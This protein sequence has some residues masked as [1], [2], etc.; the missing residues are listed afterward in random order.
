MSKSEK[1]NLSALVDGEI[2]AGAA[3][4]LARLGRDHSLRASWAR[5]HLISACLQRQLPR[6]LDTRLPLR[7]ARA[8]EAATPLQTGR[9][10]NWLNHLNL[11]LARRFNPFLLAVFKPAA[12]AAATAAVTM[13]AIIFV[14][15]QPAPGQADLDR[16][17]AAYT[18]AVEPLSRRAKVPVQAVSS[19]EYGPPPPPRAAAGD[20]TST[21]PVS[22]IPDCE[23]P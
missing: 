8:V 18:P 2:D 16:S 5:Y 15:R 23:Q 3:G 21:P 7:V 19:E 9:H 17:I 6:G 4:L 20:S 10:Q 1:E 13:L 22:A 12:F 11:G 14:A